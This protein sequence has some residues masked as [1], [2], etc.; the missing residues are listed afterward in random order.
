ML[1]GAPSFRGTGVALRRASADAADSATGTRYLAGFDTVSADPGFVTSLK[2]QAI[3]VP[4]DGWYF[5]TAHVR[6]S[7]AVSGYHRMTVNNI[8]TGEVPVL[9]TQWS[10][11]TIEAATAGVFYARAGNSLRVGMYTS[12]SA[13]FVGGDSNQYYFRVAY[14]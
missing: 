6:Y 13:S 7:S 12:S 2:D 5:G 8:T 4:V 14:L 11:P 3:I 1:S 10:S 9:G